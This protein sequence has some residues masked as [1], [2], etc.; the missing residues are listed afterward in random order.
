MNKYQ[1]SELPS[2][3]DRYPIYQLRTGLTV[4]VVVK[5]MGQQFCIDEAAT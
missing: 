1:L 3:D 2:P 5:I 4:P